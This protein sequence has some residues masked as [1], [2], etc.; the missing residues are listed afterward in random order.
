MT[1]SDPQVQLVYLKRW[2]GFMARSLSREEIENDWFP[3][4]NN[5]ELPTSLSFHLD[6]LRY[7]GFRSVDV[8]WK[9]YNFSVFGGRKD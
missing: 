3:R 4:Y 6:A 2:K 8:Y 5:D 9:Y 7:S 1:A